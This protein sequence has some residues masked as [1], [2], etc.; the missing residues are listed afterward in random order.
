MKKYLI[1]LFLLC[2]SIASAATVNVADYGDGTCSKANFDSAYA[3]ASADD[4]ITF[5][6]SG[7]CTWTATTTIAKAVTVNGNGTTLTAS[8][9]LTNGFFRVENTASADGV[10][11]IT[12]FTFKGEGEATRLVYVYALTSPNLRIDHNYFYD[13]KSPAL[14]VLTSFGVIDNN[15][16]YNNGA[17]IYGGA[18]SRA[19][20][21]ASW[22][23]MSPGTVNALFIENNHFI[24]NASYKFATTGNQIDLTAG[25]KFVIRYN[26]FDADDSPLTSNWYCMQNHGNMTAYWQNS[27]TGRRSPAIV[28][29]YNNYAHGAYLARFTTLRGG[30]QLI[31]NN[32]IVSAHYTPIISLY[33]E[34]VNLL[35]Q[36]NPARTAW[37]AEDQVHNT[38]FWGNTFNGNAQS[39][40]YI[41]V[42]TTG[43]YPSG[44]FIQKNRDYFLHAPCAAA[45]DCTHGK[46]T[47]T[48]ANGAA[49][50]NPTD[51]DP[52]ATEGTMEFTATGDNA[53][54]PYT[55]YTCP[56]ALVDPTAVLECDSASRG[57][58]VTG[59]YGLTQ[60]SAYY[61]VTLSVTG[62]GTLSPGTTQSVISGGNGSAVT[63]TPINGAWKF[64]GWSG[65]CG[66]T[67][68]STCTPTN[69]TGACTA[70]ATFESVPLLN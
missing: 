51:G 58:G 15:Y 66:C 5:P 53:Y 14:D 47:F 67:G 31:Y 39:D 28:E 61:N 12:G 54:Y 34:E 9:T 26:E 17:A 18:G 56:H 48:D 69:V 20:Q 11:R 59:G 29:I 13:G 37:P 32:T 70:E 19:L 35:G 63:A 60:E 62:S 44:E 7:S 50:S 4:T 24:I 30:S 49:G 8:G 65:T 57:A 23:T 40:A 1:I 21:D 55:A 33:E 10:F 68:T 6:V 42:Q 52:Y 43:T 46:E 38:F 64:T 2:S 41:L 16:F 22:A 27:S 3:A 25:G 45:G 36:F